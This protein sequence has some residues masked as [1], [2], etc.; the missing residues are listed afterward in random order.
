[1]IY[2]DIEIEKELEEADIKNDIY[3]VGLL[4][5]FVWDRKSKR[6]VEYTSSPSRDN[7]LIVVDTDLIKLDKDLITYLKDK[8]ITEQEALVFCINK[9]YFPIDVNKNRKGKW[10]RMKIM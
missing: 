1:M 9:T 3:Y 10:V 5:S 2:T 6:V 7:D 8:E 4:P